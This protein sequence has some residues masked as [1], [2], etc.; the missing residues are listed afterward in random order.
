V[1]A[2]EMVI[3]SLLKYIENI[4]L[5]KNGLILAQNSGK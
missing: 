1:S 3:K 4:G 5:T 2:E